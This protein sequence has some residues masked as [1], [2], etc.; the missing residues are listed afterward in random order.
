MPALLAVLIGILLGYAAGGSLAGL[1]HLELRAEWFMILLFVFQALARGRLLGLVGTSRL[2]LAVWVVASTILAGSMLQNAKTPGMLLG[3]LGILLNVDVVL[4]NW[5]MPVV[6]GAKAGL[7]AMTSAGETAA[8]TGGFY[9]I[10]TDGDLLIWLGDVIP[11]EWGRA[12]L[13]VS[14]GDVTLMVAVAV[15]IVHGMAL[16]RP[17]DKVAVEA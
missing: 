14:P 6:L 16:D 1:S 13:L 9:R 4:V 2:S 12:V 10:A 3:V 17:I 8:T 15:V 5:A 11:V 7:V